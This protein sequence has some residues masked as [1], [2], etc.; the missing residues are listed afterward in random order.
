[1]DQI[2]GMTIDSNGN[3]YVVGQTFSN[4]YPTT[5]GVFQRTR[6]SGFNLSAFVT[7]LNPSGTA[8]SY[9]TY[10]SGSGGSA[11][12]SVAVNSAGHAFVTGQAGAGFPLKT[13]LN[14]FGGYQDVF[15]AKLWAT[16]G[17]LHWSTYM[18]GSNEDYGKAVR[19]DGAGNAYVAGA[20]NSTNFPVTPGA[21]RRT[22]QGFQDIVLFKITN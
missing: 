13:P 6:Q 17:G 5:S 11:G 1:V 12:Y 7:K 16:G 3:A 19:L 2:F 22:N 4:N 15:L 14:Q 21:Y 20:T 9:S 8:L 18:G 10:L